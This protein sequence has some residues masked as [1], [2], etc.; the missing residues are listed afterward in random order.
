MH[1][2]IDYIGGE[3]IL[4]GDLVMTNA[5][6]YFNSANNTLLKVSFEVW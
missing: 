4:T 1:T 3:E 5:A 2:I 6:F